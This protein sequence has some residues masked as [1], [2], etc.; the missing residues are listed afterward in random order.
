MP[1]DNAHFREFRLSDMDLQIIP[2]SIHIL[3]E[4]FVTNRQVN[5]L[6]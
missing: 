3:V 1:K 4:I 6:K 5:E 2:W